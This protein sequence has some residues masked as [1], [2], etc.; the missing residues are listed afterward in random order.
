MKISNGRRCSC[1]VPSFSTMSLIVTY[2]AWSDTGVLILYVEPIRTSGR[3]SLSCIQMTLDP[4][5]ASAG[6]RGGIADSPRAAFAS[7]RASALSTLSGLSAFSPGLMTRY[8]TIFESILRALIV[9]TPARGASEFAVIP[10][11]EGIEKVGGGVRLSVVLDLL[12]ALERYLAAV[13]ER[14]DVCRVLQVVLLD[15]NALERLGVETERRAPLESLLVG[16]HVDVLE[17][18]VP[19]VGRDVRRFRDR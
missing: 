15:E 18:L 12:V 7:T 8:L 6:S 3:S 10:F 5:A 9:V 2:I 13:L 19:V 11:L 4:A 1:S 17:V 16:I 14:E